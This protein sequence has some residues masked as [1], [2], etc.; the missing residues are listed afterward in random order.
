MFN[1]KGWGFLSLFL[2]THLICIDQLF[3]KTNDLY[4]MIT[5]LLIYH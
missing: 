5:V 2:I 3:S 4:I 1:I